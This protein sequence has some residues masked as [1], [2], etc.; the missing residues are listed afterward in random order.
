MFWRFLL[1]YQ[2]GIFLH[3]VAAVQALPV[4]QDL[5]ITFP[6][7]GGFFLGFSFSF[8]VFP[9]DF[10][11]QQDF[12]VSGYFRISHNMFCMP[13][14]QRELVCALPPC[15]VTL[16]GFPSPFLR[17]TAVMFDI[18]DGQM[19]GFTSDKWR[20]KWG[21][22]DLSSHGKSVFSFCIGTRLS[23]NCLWQDE[24]GKQA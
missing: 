19:C 23:E 17:G 22:L 12:S 8:R 4:T 5:R 7:T 15:I 14:S 18:Q 24:S 6:S 9:A 21:L 11:F 2:G 13:A 16:T 1:R 3:Q 20:H 10:F